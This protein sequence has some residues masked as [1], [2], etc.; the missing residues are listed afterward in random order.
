MRYGSFSVETS[1][2]PSGLARLGGDAAGVGDQAVDERDVRAVQLALADEGDLHVLRHEDLG[3]EAGRR[4]I[5]RHRVGGV[6][7]GRHRQRRGA[8][9]RRAR[10]RGRQAARLERVGR[11]ERLVLDE[12]A[13]EAEIV[14][15]PPRVDQRRPAFAERERLPRRRR[16]ASARDTATWSARAPASDSR[17]QARAASRS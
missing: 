4:G 17:R 15:E 11:V 14:A 5:G 12:E 7:G 1:Y 8:E 9:M 2:Q 10:H 3:L 16:A 13:L 6:A